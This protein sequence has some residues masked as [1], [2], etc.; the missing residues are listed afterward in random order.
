[1]TWLSSHYFNDSIIDNYMIAI[2]GSVEDS[3]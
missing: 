3:C 2:I 1:M